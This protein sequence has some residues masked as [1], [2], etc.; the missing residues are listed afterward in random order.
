[1]NEKRGWHWPKIEGV[2]CGTMTDRE[3]LGLPDCYIK[4]RFEDEL[5]ELNLT[6]Q[7]K[8][9]TELVS[10]LED[11]K[12]PLAQR[13]AA[14]NLLARTC[15]PRINTLTPLM[16]EILGKEVEIGLDES[17]I[18]A[19]MRRFKHIGLDEKWILKECPKHKVNLKTFKIGKYPVTNAEYRD[20]LLATRYPE[21]PSSW[22]FR[23]YPAERANHPV[24]TLSSTA[25][26]AY[27]AWLSQSTGRSFRLPSEAEW[28]YA[29]G[30][31]EGL[32]FPWGNEF[33]PDFAN[34][35][36]T[37]LFSTSPVGVFVEGNSPF[38][39]S[40]MAGNVEEYVLDLYGAYSTGEFIADHLVQLN[41]EYRV[42]RGGCFSRL[43]DLART[44]RR[45]GRNPASSTYAMGF[46]L[47]E[48]I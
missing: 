43:R 28:E 17:E 32:E 46:R 24:Y 35:V 36:E 6:L 27:A 42:A 9:T 8:D 34:T 15:D 18:P 39:L 25:A 4:T 16:I 29:A 19:V 33:E 21:L 37:G 31:D 1:M 44:R 2:L 40:D 23:R 38:G 11:S 30:G 14:G 26:D 45:H 5:P 7:K 12:I 22:E 10:M 13:I 47:A 48:D 3:R 41:G 20:F